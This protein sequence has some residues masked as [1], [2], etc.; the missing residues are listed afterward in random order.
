MKKK[1]RK[2]AKRPISAAQR[3]S[4]DKL[5]A[6]LRNADMSKLDQ[7]LGMAIRPPRRENI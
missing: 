5:R 7:A 2:P 4:D 3:A 1:A 6:K